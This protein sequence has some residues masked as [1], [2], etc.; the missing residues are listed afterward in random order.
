MGFGGADAPLR[1]SNTMR[2]RYLLTVALLAALGVTWTWTR[3]QE[4]TPPDSPADSPVGPNYRVVFVPAPPSAAEGP[5]N[6]VTGPDGKLFAREMELAMRDL[7]KEG[8]R[9]IEVVDV[10]QGVYNY[11]GIEPVKRSGSASAMA[12]GFGY[13]Y[14][15]G[16]NIV[17]ES[18]K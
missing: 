6:L 3:A 10:I 15:S 1:E 12:Y 14:T 16:V 18:V 7:A 17:A 9:I 4:S 13:S 8:Y 11:Q 5:G 2:L